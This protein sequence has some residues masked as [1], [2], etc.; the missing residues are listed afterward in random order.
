LKIGPLFADSPDIAGQLFD[1]LTARVPGQV[2][3]FL[4]APAVN[5]AAGAFAGER[6]M[7]PVFETGRMYSRETPFVP[8]EKVFGITSFELG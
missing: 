5:P 7:T 2:P 3:V 6:N 1:A 4:D 8:M